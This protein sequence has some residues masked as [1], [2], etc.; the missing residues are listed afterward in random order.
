M[1]M[2]TGYLSKTWVK[3]CKAAEPHIPKTVLFILTLEP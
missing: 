1:N 2:E 3:Y